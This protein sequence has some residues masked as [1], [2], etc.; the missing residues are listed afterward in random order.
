[1]AEIKVNIDSLDAEI[2]KLKELK[3]KISNNKKKPSSVV[4][5]G[6]SIKEI[7]KLGNDYKNMED[8]M[9]TLVQSTISF[10]NNVKSS[11]VSGDKNAA[12]TIK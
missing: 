9:E 3:K 1:M 7:E 2:G 8:K 6:S 11:Y 12:K 5:G 4:G 10:L